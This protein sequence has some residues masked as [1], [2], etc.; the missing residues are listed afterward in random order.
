MKLV[1]FGWMML[2]LDDALTYFCVILIDVLVVGQ[3]HQ[4]M[5]QVVVGEDEETG[6]QVTVDLFQILEETQKDHICTFGTSDL[7]RKW[8]QSKQSRSQTDLVVLKELQKEGGNSG[9]DADE[10]VDHYEEHIRCT[11]NL[12]PEGCWIHDGSDGPSERKEKPLT[13]GTNLRM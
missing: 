5:A 6:F 12:E 10:E 13:K 2:H 1:L 4:A 3:L 11:G 9:S 8:L 7:C